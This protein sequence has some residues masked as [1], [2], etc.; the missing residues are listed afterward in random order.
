MAKTT[1]HGSCKCKQVTF[2]ADFDFA[3][4]GTHKCNCTWCFKH[5][6]WSIK[7]PVADFRP[8]GGEHLDKNRRCRECGVMMWALIEVNDWNPVEYYSV[9][10]AAID[11]LPLALLATSPVTF[12]DGLNDAWLSTPAHTAHL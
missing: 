9:S 10:V 4:S 12:Y 6:N 5:R 7:V 1:Y 11:D 2:E 8:V 3:A